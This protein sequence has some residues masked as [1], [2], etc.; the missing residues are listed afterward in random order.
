MATARMDWKPCEPS[1][2]LRRERGKELVVGDGGFVESEE[3]TSKDLRDACAGMGD[4]VM[5]ERASSSARAGIKAH[6]RV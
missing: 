5:C 2:S 1:S 4:L 6:V 3:G